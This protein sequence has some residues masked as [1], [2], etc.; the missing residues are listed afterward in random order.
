M[1][2]HN[3]NLLIAALSTAFIAKFDEPFTDDCAAYSPSPNDDGSFTLYSG[4]SVA[5]VFEPVEGVTATNASIT[6][7]V[8]FDNCKLNPAT[9]NYEWNGAD[10]SLRFGEYYENISFANCVGT[11]GDKDWVADCI[12]DF[13]KE[14]D[15]A[16]SKAVLEN[17]FAALTE[18]QKVAF[19]AGV[20]KETNA[21]TEPY[22][23]L[24]KA[25]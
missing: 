22:G 6:F 10:Y 4:P 5:T 13:N 14:D 24:D 3:R 17:V 23:K 7:E 19:L 2:M 20:F 12:E 25:S 18:E 15:I 9:N 8:E 1:K 16:V 21:C 11:A